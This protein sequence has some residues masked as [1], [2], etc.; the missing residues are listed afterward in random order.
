MRKNVNIAAYVCRFRLGNSTAC[1]AVWNSWMKNTTRST[2]RR[3]TTSTRFRWVSTRFRW[4]STRFGWV[5]TRFGWVSTRIGWDSTQFRW[6]STQFRWVSFYAVELDSL[7]L[8]PDT[9]FF[10]RPNTDSKY[11]FGYKMD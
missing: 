10:I 8:T 7:G 6:V 1:C 5:S 3:A 11:V 2:S 4:V 9:Y